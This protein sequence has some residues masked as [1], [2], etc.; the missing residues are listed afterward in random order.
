MK[1]LP[2]ES[3]RERE[4]E[5][6]VLELKISKFSRKVIGSVEFE[7]QSKWSVYF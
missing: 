7:R 5:N 2:F 1:R 3:E 4:R 6:E